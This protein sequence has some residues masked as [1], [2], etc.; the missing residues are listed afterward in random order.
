M[1]HPSGN[2]GPGFRATI[3]QALGAEVIGRLHDV[4]FEDDPEFGA[5]MYFDFEGQSFWLRRNGAFATLGE[6]YEEHDV[7]ILHLKSNQFKEQ[8]LNALAMSRDKR[9]P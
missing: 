7:R 1:E 2:A 6:A 9:I 3:E 4:E 5:A 8:F